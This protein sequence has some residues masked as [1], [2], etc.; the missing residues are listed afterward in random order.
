VGGRRVAPLDAMRQPTA[1][2]ARLY[3][4]LFGAANRLAIHRFIGVGHLERGLARQENAGSGLEDYWHSHSGDALVIASDLYVTRPERRRLRQQSLHPNELS[5]QR[6]KENRSLDEQDVLSARLDANARE[7]RA[8][9][10]AT[11]FERIVL[12]TDCVPLRRAR[13]PHLLLRRQCR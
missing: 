10:S 3:G 5:I 8:V 7:A 9:G 6:A 11:L 4:R 1:L 12:G 13:C 2:T